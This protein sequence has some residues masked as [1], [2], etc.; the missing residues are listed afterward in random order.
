MI[1]MYTIASIHVHVDTC[2][3]E[4]S[5]YDLLLHRTHMHG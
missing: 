2:I 4:Y 5:L 3:H 1:W